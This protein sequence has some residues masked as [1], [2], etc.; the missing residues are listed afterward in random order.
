MGSLAFYGCEGLLQA[1][2]PGSLRELAS[3]VFGDCVS[4]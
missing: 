1:E 2:I 4:L 3:S